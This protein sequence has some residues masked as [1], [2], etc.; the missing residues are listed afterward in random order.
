MLELIRMKQIVC[1]QA[2]PFAE[3]EVVRAAPVAAVAVVAPVDAPPVNVAVP[4]AN[5]GEGA[6][7]P[8]ETPD[9]TLE[10]SASNPESEAQTHGT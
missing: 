4:P 6:N 8:S 1:V 9:A 3:I 2:E 7:P 5:E 10:P